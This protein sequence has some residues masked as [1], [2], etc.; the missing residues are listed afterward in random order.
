MLSRIP[1]QDTVCNLSPSLSSEVNINQ[2]FVFVLN[3][4]LNMSHVKCKQALTEPIKLASN[5][6]V[7]RGTKSC[8][9]HRVKSLPNNS[10]RMSRRLVSQ[11]FFLNQWRSQQFF[12]CLLVPVLQV[13]N[14]VPTVAYNGII[15]NI[16]HTGRAEP[17]QE[18]LCNF[19]RNTNPACAPTKRRF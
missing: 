11:P 16:S 6:S 18:I 7:S 9:V 12:F 15:S 8:S 3:S 4:K 14:W 19:I 5:N 13:F 2:G 1:D 10:W 17:L